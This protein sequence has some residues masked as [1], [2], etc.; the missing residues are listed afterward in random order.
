MIFVVLGTQK[1]QLNRLLEILDELID[2]GMK[3]EVFA[4]IGNSDYKPR[5][6]EYTNFLEKD[7]FEE[8]IDECDI[9]ITH[10]GVGTIIS[11]MKKDK[12]VIVFP[13]LAKYGEHVDDHQIEIAESFAKM[14]YVI[15]YNEN[16]GLESLLDECKSKKFE[17]YISKRDNMISI[18]NNYLNEI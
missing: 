5:N 15:M 8:K 16:N 6:Y 2:K 9:L 10:G 7:K 12:P 18:I 14:D 1:F 3:E 4:Q 13:R 11:G 17:K